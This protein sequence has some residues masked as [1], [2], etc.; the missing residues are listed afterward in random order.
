MHADPVEEHSP[1]V[2]VGHAAANARPWRVQLGRV[3]WEEM[4]NYIGGDLKFV[5]AVVAGSIQILFYACVPKIAFGSTSCIRLKL[6]L[7]A[8]NCELPWSIHEAPD[9]TAEIA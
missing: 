8:M 9:T 4:Q 6:L 3:R 2:S 5:T 1:L 7:E